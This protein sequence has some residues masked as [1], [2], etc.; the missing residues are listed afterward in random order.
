MVGNKSLVFTG[1]PRNQYYTASGLGPQAA[2]V[3]LGSA[4]DAVHC[5][6]KP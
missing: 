5:E 2:L 4:F 1:V 3:D 6:F